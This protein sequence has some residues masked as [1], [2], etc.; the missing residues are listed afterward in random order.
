[1]DLSGFDLIAGYPYRQGSLNE[2]DGNNQAEI[3]VFRQKNA[4]H[5]IE[6]AA[7]YPNALANI[8]K[9]MD[10]NGNASGQNGTDRFDLAFR[11]RDTSPS[12]SDEIR[13]PIR[14]Q[15]GDPRLYCLWNSN[16]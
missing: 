12:D 1:L 10:L 4:F 2:L 11:N 5:A 7:A 6:A 13:Y 3:V 14:A 9:G 16:E 8:E 15:H